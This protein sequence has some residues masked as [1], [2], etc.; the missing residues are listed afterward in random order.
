MKKEMKANTQ[1]FVLEPLRNVGIWAI[2]HQIFIDR[3]FLWT[4]VEGN[5]PYSL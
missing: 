4:S 3:L 1:V 2:N 5:T